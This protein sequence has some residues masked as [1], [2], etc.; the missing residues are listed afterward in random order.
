MSISLRYSLTIGS[1]QSQRG[2]FSPL[3]RSKL[4][5]ARPSARLLFGTC[6]PN[7]LYRT[8]M[9]GTKYTH[10]Y[11]EAVLSNHRGRT[12][13]N[14][15]D[16]LLPF[17]N[18]D[19][20]LLDIGS[21]AGTITCDFAGLVGRVTALE[22]SEE[23][24]AVTRTEAERRGVHMSYCVG[25]I[26]ALPFADNTFDVVHVHQVL[27]HVSDRAAAMKEM[28][29]VVKPQG[30]VACRESV[31]S[32]FTAYPNDKGLDDWKTL[33]MDIVR[34]NGGEPDSGAML[35]DW[36]LQAGFTDVTPGIYTWCFATPETRQHWGGMWEKR[37][38]NSNIADQARS[39]GVSEN[40]LKGI[41]MAWRKW[42]DTPC[43]WY[44]VPHSHIIARK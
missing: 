22:V 19:L 32:A 31:Y 24:L 21:G 3:L 44:M 13:Y 4:W 26:H 6:L 40:E 10:G 1:L 37:I 25:D 23:A 38:L 27:Q 2:V 7:A 15:A 12:A 39:R 34:S 9:S 5:S 29:R 35:L 17:L 33:Y 42:K 8:T 16:Y 18:K 30:I 28:R 11:G 41:S 20:H 36:A 43:G 14:S